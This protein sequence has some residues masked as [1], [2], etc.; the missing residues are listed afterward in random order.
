MSLYILALRTG[1]IDYGRIKL[2]SSSHSAGS[3][4][5]NS[6]FEMMI[7]YSGSSFK[8]S[9]A[10]FGKTFGGLQ[11]MILASIMAKRSSL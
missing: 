6:A 11:E 9:K 5:M 3:R 10:K 1:H 7:G 4:F 2:W 8:S